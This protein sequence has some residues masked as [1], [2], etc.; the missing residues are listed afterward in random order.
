MKEKTTRISTLHRETLD[1]RTMRKRAKIMGWRKRGYSFMSTYA[2]LCLGVTKDDIHTIHIHT[3][4]GIIAERDRAKKKT[5]NRVCC[6]CRCC[7]CMFFLFWLVLY[8]STACSLFM[9]VL[10][11]CCLKFEYISVP[12]GICIYWHCIHSN[13]SSLHTQ[14]L[15]LHGCYFHLL[16]FLPSC[17]IH[18]EAQK[19]NFILE[20]C[21][22]FQMFNMDNYMLVDTYL[23]NAER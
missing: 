21:I 22:K 5:M 19:R 23:V 1:S 12:P 2:F 17:S 14:M 7:V 8:I 16:T 9:T 13:C 10:F 11:L 6:R 20:L 4:N 15:N 3:R 18:N